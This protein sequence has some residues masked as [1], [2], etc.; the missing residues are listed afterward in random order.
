MVAEKQSKSAVQ[1]LDRAFALLNIIAAAPDGI[2]LGV[3]AQ[4]AGL[5]PSTTHRLLG[6]LEGQGV[7]EFD[8]QG[9]VWQIGLAA[10]QIGAGFIQRRD[11]IAAARAPMRQLMQDAGETVNLAILHQHRVVFVAQIECEEVMRMAVKIGSIGPLHASAVG[12]A[13]LAFLSPE[14]AAQLIK[15]LNFPKLTAKT[16]PDNVSFENEL[17]KVRDQGFALDDEEQSRGLRC[18]AAPVF[19]EYAEPVCAIS[20][21]GPTV[22]VTADRTGQLSALVQAAADRVTQQLGGKK[23]N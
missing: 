21:S 20:I 16:L 4:K 12:K 15:R 9:G 7:V 5:A 14:L 2:A 1:S 8:G 18:I 23:P 13:M 10:F 11:F 6:A 17:Q 22:R 3:L 19:N